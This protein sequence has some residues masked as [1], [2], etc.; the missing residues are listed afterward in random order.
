MEQKN[1]FIIAGCNG[2][3]KTTASFTLLPN[4]IPCK[5]F[6]NA[7]EIARGLSPFQPEKVALQAGKI[8]LNR[9]DN[10]F[11]NKQSFAFETTLSALSIKNKILLAKKL[12][13]QVT[14]FF[15]WLNSVEMA[16]QRVKIRVQEGGHHIP[17]DVIQRRYYRGISNLFEHYLDIVDAAYLFDNSSGSPDIFAQKLPEKSLEIMNN[18]TFY[19]FKLCYENTK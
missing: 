10:L 15:F 16:M 12:G 8:M 3:G 7:D 14:L 2:S 1:L 4:I 11:A 5:E 9:I 19:E 17:N 18:N 6:L 13:Y